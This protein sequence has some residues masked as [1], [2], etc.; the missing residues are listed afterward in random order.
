VVVNREYPG[1]SRADHRRY[2]SRPRSARRS[3]RRGAAVSSTAQAT[4]RRGHHGELQIGTDLEQGAGLVQNRSRDAQPQLPEEVQ[5]TAL[6]PARTAQDILMVVFMCPR[7][8]VLDKSISQLRAR[9]QIGP[10]FAA[11]RHRRPRIFGRARLSCGSAT[12]TRSRRSEDGR[13]VAGR[14]SGAD[15]ADSRRPVRQPPIADRAF[16]ANL[17]FTGPP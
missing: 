5:R 3:M 13:D 7:R 1:R 10:A 8:H 15:P 6:S 9:M 17:T 14:R 16:P 2:G 12:P 11:G 4:Q